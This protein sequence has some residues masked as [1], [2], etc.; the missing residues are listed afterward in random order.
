MPTPK[1]REARALIYAIRNGDPKAIA[2][3]KKALKA[4]G[5]NVPAAAEAL[6]IG[7][8]TLQRWR[9]PNSGHTVPELEKRVVRKKTA[10]R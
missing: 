9:T 10:K 5:D 2:Q 6:G 3:V 1:T 8:A 4:A 7:R